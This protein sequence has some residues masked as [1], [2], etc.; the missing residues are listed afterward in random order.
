MVDDEASCGITVLSGIYLGWCG[1][2][3]VV[4]GVEVV[5]FGLEAKK[6]IYMH[7]LQYSS[8]YQNSN[9]RTPLVHLLGA[10]SHIMTI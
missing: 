2:D 3:S 5:W 7:G 6:N 1:K 9:Q 8:H 4:H 10:F